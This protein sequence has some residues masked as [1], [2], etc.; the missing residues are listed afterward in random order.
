MREQRKRGLVCGGTRGTPR[1]VS[2]LASVRTT[3]SEVMSVDARAHSRSTRP[4]RL[5]PPLSHRG[6]GRLGESTPVRGP[7]RVFSV[8]HDGEQSVSRRS[9]HSPSTRPPACLHQPSLY[10]ELTEDGRLGERTSEVVQLLMRE[11]VV[12]VALSVHEAIQHLPSRGRVRL[13]GRGG[14]CGGRG[15]A[16]AYVVGKHAR[17]LAQALQRAHEPGARSGGGHAGFGVEMTSSP[18]GF[19]SCLC[20]RR[21]VVLGRRRTTPLS[22]CSV[23]VPNAT[24]AS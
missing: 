18:L 2:Q 8:A 4:T 12:A 20:R 11:R 13:G 21:C 6:D 3:E 19:T 15:E 5:P 7:R 22:G 1:R 16:G 23:Q 24:H 10:S 9:P 17:P 14:A